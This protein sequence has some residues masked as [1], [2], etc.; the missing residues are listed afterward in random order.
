[1][2]L[3][4]DLTDLEK[5]F[6]VS[7]GELGV[8]TSEEA[9]RKELNAIAAD[10]HIPIANPSK[11]SAF[12]SFCS[13]AMIQPVCWLLAFMIRHVMPNMYVSTAGGF[14]LDLLAEAYD[15]S[16][17]PATKAAGFLTFS[18]DNSAQPVSI[19]KGTAVQTVPINGKIFRMTTDADAVIPAGEL[20]A[21]I[22][23]T[24][25]E[26]GS[27]Y[28]LGAGYYCCLNGDVPGVTA[29]TNGTDYLTEPGADEE[30]DE[31]LRLRV[32]Y[33]FAAA[34]DWHTDAKYRSMIAA[35]TGF[36]PDRI[37]FKRYD[38]ASY[39]CRGPGS[40]DAFVLF[41]SGVDPEETIVAVNSYINEEGNHGHGDSLE[42]KPVP[43]T[44][45]DVTVRVIF[46]VD[47][48]KERREAVKAEVEQIIRCAFR[49]NSQYAEITQTWPYSRFSFSN[50]GYEIH[51]HFP[52]I[53]SL[54]WGQSDIISGLDV[55]RL[56]TL[57]ITEG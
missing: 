56:N 3:N 19:P 12:W 31:Q 45:H 55:P 14:Y 52:E 25:E 7:L 6:L 28:N 54:E 15:V 48:P 5:K 30:S 21:R 44:R 16:R 9:L 38:P 29:V 43:E 26:P 46:F 51:A 20:S 27:G 10:N 23:C 50:L 17:K 22:A 34:G 57:T 13:A 8:P 42:V 49:Q 24:A 47:T 40:A 53:E 35:N 39:P 4:N 2:E 32:R 37:Y 11:Y 1:M 41:D 36:R 33:Q 18:R